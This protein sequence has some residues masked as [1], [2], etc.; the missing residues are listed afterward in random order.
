MF[1]M[2]LELIKRQFTIKEYHQ[3]PAAGIIKESERVELIRGEIVK[4]SPIGRF[5]A[6]CVNRLVRIFTREIGDRAIVAP[7]N[8]VE[9]DDYSEPQP[10]I[11]LLEPRPD[12][13]ASGHPKPADILLIVEVADS[14]IKYD[15]EVKVPLYAEDKIREVWLVDINQQ[16][17]EVY[18]EPTPNGY[19][20]VEKFQRGQSLSIQR[21]PDLAIQVAEILG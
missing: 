9:L 19:A 1:I 21:F 11:G 17:L 15:R 5:H 3:M 10:D 16:C 20:Q 7:Q 6:A 13:Y 8:P 4:M 12:F 14:T 2:S 18:R